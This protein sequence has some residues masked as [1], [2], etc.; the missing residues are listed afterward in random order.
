MRY[1]DTEGSEEYREFVIQEFA[2]RI[3]FDYGQAY[4]ECCC[5]MDGPKKVVWE[6]MSIHRIGKCED[7]MHHFL[8]KGNCGP[9]KGHWN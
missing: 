9:R 6:E 7:V 2:K 8:I 3:H 5:P 4:H 1:H